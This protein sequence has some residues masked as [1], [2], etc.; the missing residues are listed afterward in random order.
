VTSAAAF[1]D[2][3]AG[4]LTPLIPYIEGASP[5]SPLGGD[6]YTSTEYAHDQPIALHNELSYSTQWPG[7]TAFCCTT[8]AAHGGQTPLADSRRVYD[9]IVASCA[10]PIPVAIR[11]V[12]HMHDGKGPGVGWPVVFGTSDATQ[13][14][15]YCRKA[16]IDHAWLPNRVLRTSQ[17]RPTAIIHPRTGDRIWFNQAH[18][19]HPS[20]GGPEAEALWRELFGDELPMTALHADGT[21][22]D[23]ALL[24][25]VRDAYQAE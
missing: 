18:Q 10:R 6:I 24:A 17:T 13:V 1:R 19:W 7:R 4:P 14:V 2:T 16:D 3:V 23:E 22:I 20:N 15:D 9:R 11:Y 5:R 21:E 8:P 12:R 25:A